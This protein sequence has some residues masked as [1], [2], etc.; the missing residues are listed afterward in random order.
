MAAFVRIS[1]MSLIAELQRRN[2][3]RA[4]VLYAGA[5]WAL[6]QGLAQLL[7]LFGHYGWIARWFV[8]AA[9][10]GF[11]FWIAF[12][13][14]Y[15]FTPQGLK[16]ESEIAAD[17]SIA[18]STGSKL[19]KWI[20]AVLGIAVVLLLTNLFVWHKGAGL[21]PSAV[22]PDVLANI[23]AKS[24]AVLPFENL[25]TDKGNQYFADGMQDLIL[26]KLAVIGDMKVI[27]RTSTEK[28]ESH[29]D[30]LKAIA[31]QLGVATILEGSVQKAG[32]QVL[33]NVQLINARSDNHLWA[34]SYQR[35]LDNIFGVE[36]EVAQKVADALK[37]K[38]TQ[39][40]QQ[41][42]SAV[43]TQNPAAYDAFLKAESLAYKA[44]DS[45]R[46]P[47][48]LAAD[49][50]YRQAIVLDPGFALAYARLAYNRMAGHWFAKHLSP[51]QLGEVKATVDRALALAPELP[52]V[53]LA[54]AY[55]YYWGF[56][57]YDDA[58]AQ[59][60]RTLQL[61]PNNERAAQG[62]AYILR[63]RGQF[64]QALTQFQRVLTLAPADRQNWGEYGITYEVL[65]RYPEALAQLNRALAIDPDYE[66]ARDFLV[67]ALLFGFGDVAKA[68]TASAGTNNWRLTYTIAGDSYNL[69]G[70]RAYPDF[71]D[72]KFDAALRDWDAVPTT[73]NEE[74]LISRVARVVIGMVA[75]RQ[76]GI[77][78][79][80]VKLKPL[81]DAD[82]AKNP[83]ALGPLQRLSWIEVCLG[84]N[85]DAIA[86]ARHASEALPLAKDAYFGAFQLE[87][88]A[89]I[90]A[91]AGQPEQ[92]IDLLQ[93][94]L[95]IP[96]GETVSIERLEL[97][98]MWDPLRRNPRFQALLK[99]YSAAQPMAT[100]IGASP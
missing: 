48:F 65:R 60:Q 11:P 67:R 94:L 71:F 5:T 100:R 34:E 95:S 20:I 55:Y 83:D 96:A 54:L 63:R 80:C 87:G 12:A 44:I 30:N 92:A 74:R 56:R 90:E 37:A 76:A 45:Y 46:E 1:D 17:A 7:P 2:V 93:K 50:A 66:D 14:F 35:T 9:V 42:V 22:N 99:K 29:P 98:P 84:R 25:S 78:P 52:D 16:R 62:L 31:Q 24:I 39:T 3:L 64:D 13:W 82:L 51:E 27:S 81:L 33:I 21:R 49:A 97:D 6:A 58:T 28:Y 36:G 88:L 68:R 70:P 19:D 43:P 53:H 10:I 26:T 4:A 47:D 91:H 73:K 57:R 61:A 15:E 40:E 69:I 41:N 38:I 89:E 72:R 32:N 85:A 86:T 77:W 18:R 23:P 75:G 79:E 59:F 8:I